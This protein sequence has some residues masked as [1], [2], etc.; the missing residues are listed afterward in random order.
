MPTSLPEMKLNGIERQC[1]EMGFK[2]I[3]IKFRTSKHFKFGSLQPR[4]LFQNK[5]QELVLK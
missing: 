2:K 1:A 3:F 4:Q 5:T